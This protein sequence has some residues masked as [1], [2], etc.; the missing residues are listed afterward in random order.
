M[1]ERH[2]MRDQR[3]VSRAEK[4]GIKTCF[5]IVVTLITSA[6]NPY[7][8]EESKQRDS[9]NSETIKTTLSN[10]P[11]SEESLLRSIDLGG[12]K[13]DNHNDN[14]EYNP[15]HIVSLTFKINK[16]SPIFGLSR[17]G[18]AEINRDNND[19][20]RLRFFKSYYSNIG[21]DIDYFKTRMIRHLGF[22]THIIES[23]SNDSKS[24][25]ASY[26]TDSRNLSDNRGD[27]SCLSM[28]G[29]PNECTFYNPMECHSS[30]SSRLYLNIKARRYS[31]KS[32]GEHATLI[33]VEMSDTTGLD[34]SKARVS[35]R[36]QCF[37]ET[38][39]GNQ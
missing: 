29:N 26:S 10:G 22:P 19:F 3:I 11:K 25:E 36:S 18:F 1:T 38:R 13:F 35:T 32:T 2:F 8:A 27:R 20:G 12:I 15:G 24:F 9:F 23:N 7:V 28:F 16:T 39:K 14:I 37:S 4:I 34:I 31:S 5:A 33:T 30:R 6:C 21:L 17:D